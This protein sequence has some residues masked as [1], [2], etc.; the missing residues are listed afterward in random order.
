MD[1]VKRAGA[2]VTMRFAMGINF[3]NAGIYGVTNTHTHTHTH[4][5]TLVNLN[6]KFWR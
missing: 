4:T 6:W 3:W 1:E 5:H 2:D